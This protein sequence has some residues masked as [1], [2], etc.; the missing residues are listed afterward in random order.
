MAGRLL[1]VGGWA[2]AGSPGRWVAGRPGCCG[3]AAWLLGG[4]GFGRLGSSLAF[5]CLWVS[6][7]C[8]GVSWRGRGGLLGSFCRGS[9]LLGPWG[10]ACACGVGLVGA[11]WAWGRVRAPVGGL[12]W[13]WGGPGCPWGPVGGALGSPQVR[14]VGCLCL[15][16]GCFSSHTLWPTGR[17]IWGGSPASWL[18]THPFPAAPGKPYIFQLLFVFV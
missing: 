9:G 3:G 6:W 7:W 1:G 4:L 13:P 18:C 15:C 5:R 11:L 16:L 10:G 14:V 17:L 8:S 12:G 2:V